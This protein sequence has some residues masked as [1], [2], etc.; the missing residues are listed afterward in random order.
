MTW[1]IPWM[2]TNKTAKR[3]EDNKYS[4]TIYNKYK[5]GEAVVIFSTKTRASK[6]SMRRIP[7]PSHQGESRRWI[8]PHGSSRLPDRK[9]EKS[10]LDSRSLVLST[11][12]LHHLALLSLSRDFW[13]FL[14]IPHSCHKCCRLTCRCPQWFQPRQNRKSRNESSFI[15]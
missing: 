1:H 10:L 12:V 8:S 11:Q 9:F 3:R 13:W 14:M 5:I 2:K 4:R 15:H 7:P 6:G